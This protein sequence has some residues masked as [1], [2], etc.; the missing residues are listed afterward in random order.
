MDDKLKYLTTL[1]T[2][3]DATDAE[4]TKLKAEIQSETDG[5]LKSGSRAKGATPTSNSRSS[6]RRSQCSLW[7]ATY[8]LRMTKM[9]LRPVLSA[10][11]N[12]R[13]C[14]SILLMN[15][16]KSAALSADSWPRLSVPATEC[17]AAWR[18]IRVA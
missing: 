7:S 3:R 17:D 15:K 14:K 9:T 5:F 10:A 1:K 13:R 8:P 18:P 4:I 11:K 12:P 16:K 2:Q 6:N